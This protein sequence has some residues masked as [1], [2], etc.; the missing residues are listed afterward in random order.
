MKK[1]LIPVL[2][3]L[4][5]C[6][7]LTSCA[8]LKVGPA[9]YVHKN[10]SFSITYPSDWTKGIDPESLLF[11]YTGPYKLPDLRVKKATSL[12]SPEDSAKSLCA[13]LKKGSKAQTC[14]ILYTKKI[15]LSDGTPA[16]EVYVEWRHPQVMLHSTQV[17]AEKGKTAISAVI[18]NMGEIDEGLKA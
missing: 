6:S 17:K 13:V 2:V 12:G 11:A 8:G 7:L 3:A 4:A 16:H 10:P 9:K 18:T 14:K 5:S 1:V 15:T